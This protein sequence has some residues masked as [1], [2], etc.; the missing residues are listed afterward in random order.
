MS[1][2]FLILF[3]CASPEQQLVKEQCKCD[4]MDDNEKLNCFED[5]E[6]EFS[7]EVIANMDPQKLADAMLN[8]SCN[9]DGEAFVAMD[10]DKALQAAEQIIEYHKKALE[11]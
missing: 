1:A 3:A 5:V 2:L 10:S 4:Q 8:S 6:E 11:N 7:S 9:Q